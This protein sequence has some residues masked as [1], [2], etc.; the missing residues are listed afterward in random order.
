MTFLLYLEALVG[1]NLM[2]QELKIVAAQ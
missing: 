1:L 2:G